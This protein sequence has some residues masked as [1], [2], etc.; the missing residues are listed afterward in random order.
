MHLTSLPNTCWRRVVSLVGSLVGV[1][2]K[3]LVV[4]HREATVGKVKPACMRIH[5][6]RVRPRNSHILPRVSVV[7]LVGR[8]V[9]RIHRFFLYEAA[10]GSC[11]LPLQEDIVRL[12]FQLLV[13][14]AHARNS[15]RVG[16]YSKRLWLGARNVVDVHSWLPVNLFWLA[17]GVLR[18]RISDRSRA[19]GN[20]WLVA[21]DWLLPYL[22]LL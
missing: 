4:G 3:L 22:L 19:L 13:S 5:S 14:R 18:H 1:F 8:L 21:G 6:N 11:V 9:M 20:S 10:R 12:V 15:L 16:V 17:A 7:C 2:L